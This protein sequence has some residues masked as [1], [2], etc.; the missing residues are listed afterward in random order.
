VTWAALS[1]LT[2][3][4]PASGNARRA[5]C[6]RIVRKLGPLESAAAEGG[7]SVPAITHALHWKALGPPCLLALMRLAGD[8]ATGYGPVTP[9]VAAFERWLA[10][11]ADANAPPWT[12]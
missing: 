1:A 10:E 7:D 6:R 9:S 5:A 3:F 11:H 12:D 8:P 2:V 4:G